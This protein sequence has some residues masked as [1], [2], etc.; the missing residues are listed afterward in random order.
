MLSQ[1]DVK[2]HDRMSSKDNLFEEHTIDDLLISISSRTNHEQLL[3]VLVCCT[4]EI[5]EKHIKENRW[6]KTC[7]GTMNANIHDPSTSTS[8]MLPSTSTRT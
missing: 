2:M 3:G 6:L 5:C 8:N 7:T 1:N 4:L